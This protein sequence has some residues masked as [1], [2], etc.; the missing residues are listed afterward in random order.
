MVRVRGRVRVRGGRG[1]AHPRGAVGLVA[2]AVLKRVPPPE[3]Q[4]RGELVHEAALVLAAAP[5]GEEHPRPGRHED[6]VGGVR[7]LHADQ[8]VGASEA[9]RLTMQVLRF[10]LP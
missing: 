4:L 7:P 8:Q 9:L 1:R 5:G 10:G 6:H 3:T 2:G